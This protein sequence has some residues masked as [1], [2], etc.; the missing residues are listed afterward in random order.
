MAN[1]YTKIHLQFVFAVKYRR[2]LIQAAWENELYKYITG[3]VQN[4][5]HKMLAINGVEDHIHILVGMRPSQSISDLLRDIK[6]DSAL[7]I[8]ESKFIDTKFE[9]QAGYGAFSYSPEAVKN[10]I[11]YILNQKE[12]HKN[13]L[14]KQEYLDLLA[15]H[16]VEYD[17]QFIFE[18]PI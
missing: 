15:Y 7:W 2:A 8:N 13:Q 3:I 10:V 4:H 14:F 5:N 12:H 1:T 6:G 9:W 17:P 18:D 16:E 11:K